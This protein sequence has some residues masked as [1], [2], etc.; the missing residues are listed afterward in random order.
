MIS[1]E[2]GC[3]KSYYLR[4]RFRDLVKSIYV[5]IIENKGNKKRST[6][7]PAYIS[8]YGVS[9]TEDFEYRVFCGINAWAENGFIRTGGAIAAKGASIFGLQFGKKDSSAITFVNENR[10]L[11]FD[12]LERICEDKIPVKE[13]LGLINSYAEHTHRKVIIVC[14]EEHFLSEGYDHKLREDYLKY[15]EKS[16]RF[17]YSYKANV[18]TAYETMVMELSPSEYRDYLNVNKLAILLLFSIGDNKNLRTLKFFIDAFKEIYNTVK[19]TKYEEQVVSSYLLSFML[20]TIEHKDGH[21]KDELESLDTSKYKID[22]SFF[23]AF[24][25]E[26]EPQQ[27]EK[28]ID[29]PTMFEQKYKNVFSQFRSN[30]LFIDY[31]FSGYLD[32]DALKKDVAVIVTEYDRQVLTPEG[33]VYNSLNMMT[34]IKD[35]DVRPK[36]EEML[37]YV[38]AD[39]Y[40]LYDLL[41]VYALLLKYDYWKIS[42]FKLTDD[43]DAE[44]AASMDRQQTMHLF[45]RMFEVNTPYF[46][47]TSYSQILFEKYT[48]LKKHA[49]DINWQSK[50]KQD[51]TAGEEYVQV[52]KEGNL[53]KLRKY[54]ETPYSRIPIVGIDWKEI[55][56]IILT[57]ANPVACEVCDDIIFF[58][59]DSS[60]VTSDERERMNEDLLPAIEDYFKRED[61]RIRK[62]YV[63]ELRNHIKDVLS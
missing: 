56:N 8:L 2:W 36:I 29:F 28:K 44:F 51:M 13:V 46:E 21:S 38:K 19:G 5:P 50:Q 17:T 33:M 16:V 58:V 60:V 43:I 22:T 49:I 18:E 35:E 27:E 42:D 63:N 39:K 7:N 54:R 15:K 61:N 53:E 57:A 23:S 48:V 52:A 47:K 20:Y 31:I 26:S 25:Q 30:N 34:T 3:G 6:Y 11:V 45:N 37:S 9:S 1:G 59:P 4:N 55:V 14:N 32:K 62:V 24:R 12:D 41:K 10:V 40:N